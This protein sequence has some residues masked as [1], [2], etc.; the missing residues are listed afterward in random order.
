MNIKIYALIGG[1]IKDDIKELSNGVN[2]VIGTPG[3]VLE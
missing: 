2:I 1:I 3:R